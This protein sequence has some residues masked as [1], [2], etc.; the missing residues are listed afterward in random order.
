M[1]LLAALGIVGDTTGFWP[2]GLRR[3]AREV[4]ANEG[5][6]EQK[7][8]AAREKPYSNRPQKGLTSIADT[9]LGTLSNLRQ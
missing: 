9:S 7:K 8:F 2:D 4:I 3:Q 5:T 1:T 6:E